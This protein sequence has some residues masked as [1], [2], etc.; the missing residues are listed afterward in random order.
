MEE[1]FFDLFEAQV[2][3]LR[4]AYE[5]ECRFKNEAHLFILKRGLLEDFNIFI[6]NYKG[7]AYEDCV[8]YLESMRRL[9]GIS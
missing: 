9:R 4:K 3:D 8:E 5:T 1:N 2:K 7:N 6:E